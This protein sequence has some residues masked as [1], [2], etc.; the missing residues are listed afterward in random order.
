MNKIKIIYSSL[1]ENLVGAFFGRNSKFCVHATRHLL[2]S[3]V[4][5][6]QYV[7]FKERLGIR[8]DRGR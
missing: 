3:G 6:D 4:R 8:V 2:L 5:T 1:Y 7:V